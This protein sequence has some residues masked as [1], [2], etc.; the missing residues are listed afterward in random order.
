VGIIKDNINNMKIEFRNNKHTIKE[1][2]RLCSSFSN[3][4]IAEIPSITRHVKKDQGDQILPELI[5]LKCDNC[6]SIN[7]AGEKPVIG[8]QDNDFINGFWL[9]YAQVGA[10]ISGMLEPLFALGDK[11]TGNLLDIGCGFG[12]IVDFW[13]R[14]GYGKALGLEKAIYGG[15]GSR[16]LGAPIISKYYDEY[17]SGDDTKYNIV[18]CSEV[19]EHVSD[20]KQFIL[21]ISDALS[22]EGILILTTP[23]ADAV[24]PSN[25]NSI[26]IGA[27]SPHLHY[28]VSSEKALKDLLAECNLEYFKVHNTGT[29]L[30]AWASKN[31]LPK[32]EV[33]RISWNDYF[34]YL[35]ILSNNE[36]SNIASGA[37]Y[38][39]F[40]DAWNTGQIERAREAYY[41]FEKYVLDSYNLSL[42]KPNITR[43]EK[44][45]S[46]IEGIDKNP[47]W[48]GCS[49]LFGGLIIGKYEK[50]YSTK[51]RMIDA[52]VQILKLECEN[53]D[54]SQ[55][56][57]EAQYFYPEAKKQLRIAYIEA[58][59]NEIGENILVRNEIAAIINDSIIHRCIQ[60]IRSDIRWWSKNWRSR[61]KI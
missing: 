17:K 8:Y 46:L 2:C 49:L 21:N 20:P 39:L 40:K 61:L 30:F 41:R 43:Y 48:Y 24:T 34:S 15:I 52:A 57:L 19:I 36:D 50:D 12:Y 29:R 51:V 13:N 58:A 5:V 28:F 56:G 38:R 18:Y 25:S 22:S 59:K 53:E 26:V 14:I 44:R 32:I 47:S 33:G 54:F 9:H 60:R 10:G 45:K 11:C 42:R 16:L 6:G 37:I 27:L 55:F 31:P 1:K 35:E 4:K 3:E 7:Y 23:S